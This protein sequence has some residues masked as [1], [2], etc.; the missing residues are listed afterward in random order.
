[1]VKDGLWWEF[2]GQ[3]AT[4]VIA[5]KL[6]TQF[7]RQALKNPRLRNL[8]THYDFRR[9]LIKVC[10]EMAPRVVNDRS[11][12]LEINAAE[13]RFQQLSRSPPQ[14]ETISGTEPRQFQVAQ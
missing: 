3:C 10:E 1:M 12:M 2:I 8:A 5:G 14:T 9:S 6:T 11:L 4:D 7:L 13:R